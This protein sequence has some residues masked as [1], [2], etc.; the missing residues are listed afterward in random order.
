MRRV[1]GGREGKEFGDGDEG[2][3]TGGC[4]YFNAADWFKQRDSRC[5]MMMFR[6]AMLALYRKWSTLFSRSLSQSS[7]HADVHMI[8]P[9]RSTAVNSFKKRPIRLKVTVEQDRRIW[10][11]FRL[12]VRSDAISFGQ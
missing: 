8:N 5:K 10:A 4:L 7:R 2:G 6:H 3:S 12:P 11:F 1:G 9:L